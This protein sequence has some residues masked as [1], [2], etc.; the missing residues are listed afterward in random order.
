MNK[1]W[2]LKLPKDK[3]VIDIL[4]II[5]ADENDVKIISVF[6]E[7]MFDLKSPKKISK[8]TGVPLEKVIERCNAMAERGVILKMGKK[9]GIF[10]AMPGLIEF[11][12]IAGKDKEEMK[13]GAK[14]LQDNFG[15]IAPEWFASG[16]PFFR[17]LPSSSLKEKSIE[18]NQ[19][20]E[21][22]GQKFLVYEDI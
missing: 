20:I 11:Y 3:S 15:K 21:D 18:I 12:F 5:Y 2:P 14:L 9:F 10:P 22:V 7:P 6:R 16:Y 8:I 4:K 19:D 1:N 17:N 13:L